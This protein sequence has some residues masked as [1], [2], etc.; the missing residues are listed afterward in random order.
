MVFLNIF[1]HRKWHIFLKL[2]QCWKLWIL[3]FL[4]FTTVFKFIPNHGWQ[5]ECLP[6][7][8]NENEVF[9]VE[10][11]QKINVRFQ[12]SNQTIGHDVI[13]KNKA[14]GYQVKVTSS[15]ISNM[16]TFNWCCYC[17]VLRMTWIVMVIPLQ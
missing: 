4:K 17:A 5:W 3:N 1:N 2:I 8:K 13:F 11:M 15:M 14:P 6:R 16:V 10:I 12:V 9:S 7:I